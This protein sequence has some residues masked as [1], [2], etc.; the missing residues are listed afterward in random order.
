MVCSKFSHSKL[1]ETSNVTKKSSFEASVQS[2]LGEESI[3]SLLHE[4]VFLNIQ[5]IEKSIDYIT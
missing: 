1:F 3:G 4:F 2:A 5:I